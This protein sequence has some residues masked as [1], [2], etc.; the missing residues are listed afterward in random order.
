MCLQ[1]VYYSISMPDPGVCCRSGHFRLQNSVHL[2]FTF[3]FHRHR[4]VTKIKQHE[5]HFS[6][7]GIMTSLLVA[8]TETICRP[9]VARQCHSRSHT[10]SSEQLAMCDHFTAP[11]INILCFYFSSLST[12]D[13]KFLTAKIFQYVG[14]QCICTYMYIAI[15]S[16]I[17]SKVISYKAS[18]VV[19]G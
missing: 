14:G 16:I 7:Y 2:I 6:Q 9:Q 17:F 12:T 1:S 5:K 19:A 10:F 18:G 15:P 8:I 11:I 13:E 4:P 3:T